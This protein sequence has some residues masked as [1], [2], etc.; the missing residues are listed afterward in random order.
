MLLIYLRQIVLLLPPGKPSLTWTLLYQRHWALC[1]VIR[2]ILQLISLLRFRLG[3]MR[4]N[5]QQRSYR[6][7]LPMQYLLM[8]CVVASLTLCRLSPILKIL[9]SPWSLEDD[10]IIHQFFAPAL[11]GCPLYLPIER[12]LQLQTPSSPGWLWFDFLWF[13]PVSYY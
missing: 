13:Y 5:A 3:V 7:M 11:F 1:L 9:C 10:M 4:L 2:I 8:V 12:D 6:L